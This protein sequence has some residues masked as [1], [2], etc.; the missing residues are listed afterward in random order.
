MKW[1]DPTNPETQA[2]VAVLMAVLAALGSGAINFPLGIPQHWVDILKSWDSTIVAIYV[3]VNGYF[4]GASRGSGPW[5]GT[6]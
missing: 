2:Y 4:N 5:S 3:V 1:Y 6:K